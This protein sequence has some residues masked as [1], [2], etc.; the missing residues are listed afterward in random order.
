MSRGRRVC[1]QLVESAPD[2]LI[3]RHVKRHAGELVRLARNL[4]ER[5]EDLPAPQSSDPETSVT[6]CSTPS[7]DC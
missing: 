4:A 1:S 5:S 3:A 7:P 2:E 6:C